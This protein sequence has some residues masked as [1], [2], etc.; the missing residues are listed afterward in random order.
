M[1]PL[2]V[3][4]VEDEGITAESLSDVLKQL[5]YKVAGIAANALDAI[6]ILNTE[7]ADIA[8]LDINIQG[9]KDGLWLA[10]LIQKKYHIPFIFLTAFEDEKVMDEAI[11]TRPG[12]YLLKPFTK[13]DIYAAIRL[14]IQN[15]GQN[16]F[17]TQKKVEVD[18]D[19][20]E[21]FKPVQ[22]S[23]SIYIKNDYLFNKV[24][25]DDIIILKSDGH[26]LEI[27]TKEKKYLV[28]S[29]LS[30]FSDVLPEQMFIRVN[31]SY[32]VNIN[33]IEKF[34]PTFLFVHGKEIPL[35]KAYRNELSD[36]LK[37]I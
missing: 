10:G 14:A 29:K 20:D 31:R 7:S 23:G 24:I 6:D 5:G 15:Y 17:S 11:K 12:A 4:I 21:D 8:I 35:G 27:I 3:L 33:C 1:E 37:T 16:N 9:D 18:D 25:I 13:S 2:S 28:R 30:D 32:M 34:G 19:G 36:R 22:L 26:Y